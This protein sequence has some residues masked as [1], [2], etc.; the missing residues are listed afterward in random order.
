MHTL[1]NRAQRDAEPLP[2]PGAHD[3]SVAS[4]RTPAHL[5]VRTEAPNECE[6][7]RR[8]RRRRGRSVVAAG[9]SLAGP[10]AVN[11]ELLHLQFSYLILVSENQ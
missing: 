8:R 7:T 6:R 11:E 2:L 3:A 4:V 5:S 1:A 9:V 10:R